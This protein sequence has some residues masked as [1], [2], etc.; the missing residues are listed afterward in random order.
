[1]HDHLLG[2]LL[3]LDQRCH[4]PPHTQASRRPV[5]PLR[6][7]GALLSGEPAAAEPTTAELMIRRLWTRPSI[8]SCV[9]SPAAASLG[10]LSLFSFP[11]PR[12]ASFSPC[13]H[14]PLI[15]SPLFHHSLSFFLSHLMRPLTWIF[16]LSTLQVHSGSLARALADAPS[17]FSARRVTSGALVLFSERKAGGTGHGEKR[18][19]R[20]GGI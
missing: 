15:P 12:I 1:M 17:P 7:T 4:R 14:N 10:F 19:M 11:P 16:T 20:P 2:A 3:P 8:S 9:S 6:S 5:V 18:G 13:H